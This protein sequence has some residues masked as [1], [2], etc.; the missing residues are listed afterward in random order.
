MAI[1]PWPWDYSLDDI[2]IGWGIKC[3]IND[4]MNV[5]EKLNLFIKA[6]IIKIFW[7][8]TCLSRDL[9]MF[10]DKTIVVRHAESKK[11]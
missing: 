8:Q 1:W 9:K 2:G 5:Y 10:W 3:D 4:F 7:W 11:T 6:L